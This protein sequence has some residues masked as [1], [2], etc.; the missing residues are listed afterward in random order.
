MIYWKPFYQSVS[1]VTR[2]ACRRKSVGQVLLNPFVQIGDFIDDAYSA[3]LAELRSAADARV[4]R[5]S[6]RTDGQTLFDAVFSRL[7]A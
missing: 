2:N 5:Q 7:P 1:V 3:E 6:F 4:F